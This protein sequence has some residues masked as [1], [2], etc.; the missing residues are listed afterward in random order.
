MRAL[1]DRINGLEKENL[2]YQEQLQMLEV[3]YYKKAKDLEQ[4]YLGQLEESQQ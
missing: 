2:H 1:Q 3:S 4:R